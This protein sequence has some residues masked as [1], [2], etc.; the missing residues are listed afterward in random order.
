MI[1]IKN[2]ATTTTTT[3]ANI[4]VDEEGNFRV[5]HKQSK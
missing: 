1:S 5:K 4:S 2:E 3:T